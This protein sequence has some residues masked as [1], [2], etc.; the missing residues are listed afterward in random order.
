MNETNEL[1]EKLIQ[2]F[3]YI[4]NQDSPPNINNTIKKQLFKRI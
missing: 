2:F 4:E 3:R 1:R